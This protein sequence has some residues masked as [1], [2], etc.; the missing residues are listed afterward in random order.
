MH[1]KDLLTKYHLENCK[2]LP[3]SLSVTLGKSRQ[4]VHSLEK[5]SDL[6]LYLIFVN[7]YVKLELEDTRR[8]TLLHVV[9]IERIRKNQ[10]YYNTLHS[11]FKSG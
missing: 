11:H 9:F 3:S 4:Y 7:R 1:F 6:P 10:E 2:H 8:H 5:G